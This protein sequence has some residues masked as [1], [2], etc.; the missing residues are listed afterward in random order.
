MFDVSVHNQDNLSNSYSDAQLA[1]SICYKPSIEAAF[2]AAP[3]LSGKNAL[4][5]TKH[6]T[7]LMHANHYVSFIL[8]KIPVSLVTF[9][10]HL[11]NTYYNSSQRSGR[12]C[13]SMF[14]ADYKDYVVKFID[15]Y[16]SLDSTSEI[17]RDILNW[18]QHGVNYFKTNLP[19]IAEKAGEAIL[20]E[21]PN[22]AGD[23]NEQSHRIA[24]EQLR[25]VISTIFPTGMMFT[26]DIP[27]LVALYECAW[28]IPLANLTKR[29][30]DS[31]FKNSS[32]GSLVE[33]ENP[34]K[35]FYIGD[36]RYRQAKKKLGD[37]L[38]LNYTPAFLNFTPTV[39][40]APKCV[41]SNDN[42]AQLN[43]MIFKR[44]T[45]IQENTSVD[46]LPFSPNANMLNDGFVDPTIESK[47]S[48]SV[49]T[50]GQDQRHRSID[51]GLPVVTGEIYVPPLLRGCDNFFKKH[52]KTYLDLAK[53]GGIENL[54][55][56]IPYGAVVSYTKRADFRAFH[57]E[58][59][60][61][62]CLN[63]QEEIAQ[64]SKLTIDQLFGNSSVD[65]PGPPCLIHGQCEEGKRYCG[66]EIAGDFYRTLI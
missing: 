52:M 10:L 46:T 14:D 21:R 6:H 18:V 60:K 61:R 65:R 7:T 13:T 23:L 19:R 25:Y 30:Y 38:E 15:R 47:V 8:D 16:T 43:A 3:K 37:A 45:R 5:K 64:L 1:G 66:R 63:A 35:M 31:V 55:H 50:F 33:D 53:R 40:W 20:D 36:R 54:I 49:A 41:V 26:I 2:I 42:S 56:F 29:M 11:Q 57:H 28:N 12:F 4:W 9:G 34:D 39:I 27:T 32:L 59:T 51:R 58:T 48:V 62:L 17:G 24:Q 44:L 22:Y